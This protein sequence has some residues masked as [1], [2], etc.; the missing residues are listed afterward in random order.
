MNNAIDAL[1]EAIKKNSFSGKEYPQ[2]RIS[3]QLIQQD[4]VQICII[5]NG[6]GIPEVNISKLFDPFFTTKP[7]GQG[8]GL[9]LSISYQIIVEQHQGQLNCIYTVGESTEFQIQIPISC[10]SYKVKD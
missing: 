10:K 8:T 9:G 6:L 3:T 1:E 7:V 4:I 5:D 2:I